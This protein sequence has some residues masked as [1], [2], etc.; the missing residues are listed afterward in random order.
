MNGYFF[1][2]FSILLFIYNIFLLSYHRES[3]SEPLKIL[4]YFHVLILSTFY[5]YCFTSSVFFFLHV[6]M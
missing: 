6:F 4:I 3:H 1:Q 2:A 5:Y